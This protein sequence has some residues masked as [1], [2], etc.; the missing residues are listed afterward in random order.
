M[1]PDRLKQL[2]ALADE[3]SDMQED[4]VGTVEFT[5]DDCRAIA[6]INLSE[7]KNVLTIEQFKALQKFVFVNQ[8]TH[9]EDG[10]ND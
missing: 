8:I 6:K 9:G 1:T 2:E 5:H 4:T 10:Q 7:L 3:E